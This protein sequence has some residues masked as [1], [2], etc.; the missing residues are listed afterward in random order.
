M[1]N[2][3]P[4]RTSLTE[5][6]TQ[7][8]VPVSTGQAENYVLLLVLLS[9]FAGG[10]LV[11]LSL[12]LLFCHRCCLGGRRYSRAS[13]DPEKT[14]TTYAEDSQPTQ[15]I[16]IRLDESDALSASSC[17]DGESDRF[18]STGSTGRRVSFNESALYDQEKNTQEKGRRYTLTEG[19]FHHLKKARLTHLHLPPAP[20][21]LKILTIMECDSTE[22][23][24][25]NISE[26]SAPN[27][28]L[29]IYQPAERGVPDWLG[30]SLSGGL[31]GDPH[32]STVLDQRDL[33]SSSV[34]KS[35]RSQT[36]E[37]IGD[38]G[39]AESEW[40]P[41]GEPAQAPGP[42]S[43]LHFLSKLRRHASLEG[44]GPYFRR[45][46][47]DTSHRAASLDA[48]GSPKRKP[49]QR[50]RAASE[51]TDHTDE[52]SSPFRDDAFESFPHIPIQTS[53]LQFLSAETL[54]HPETAPTSCIFLRR[55]KLEAMVE[56]GGSATTSSSRRAEL[57][58]PSDPALG[59]VEPAV[60]GT[61]A[62]QET[63]FG[64]AIRTKAT[65]NESE[66]AEDDDPFGAEQGP[67]RRDRF[68]ELLRQTEDAKTDVG[69]AGVRKKNNAG[70][71]EGDDAALG[72]VARRRTDS[73]SSLSFMIRQESSE[74]PPSLYRDI[75]SLRA[76]LEQYA[77][78]DQSSTDRESVRSDADSVSSF[79]GARS[80][81]D[82]CLSQDLDDEPEG[83]GEVEGGT[84]GASGGVG[85]MGNGAGGEA[86]GG[87]RKLLQM[88]SGYA[89]IEA[90]S[91]APEDMRLFGTP[92]APRGK[93]ASERRLFF[94]SSGRK[95]SVCESVETKLFQ[96][97]L[98]DQMA[99]T[100]D[101]EDRL[102]QKSQGDGLSHTLQEPYQLLK[103][104]HPQKPPE[105]QTQLISPL[106]SPTPQPPSPHRSR[107]RRRDYSIDEKT[108]ALFNEFLRH[109]PRFDQQDS[110][111]RSRH[112]SRVHLRKQWQRHKQ[113]SDPGSASGG[114]Y[115]P[116][117][118]RQRFTPLRR[119]DSAGYP[120]DTRYHSTLSRIASAADE[121][122]SEVAASEEAAT[123]RAEDPVGEAA[124][125]GSTAGQTSDGA[126]PTRSVSAELAGETDGCQV[127]TSKE[128][129]SASSTLSAQFSLMDPRVDNRNNNSSQ[130]ILSEVSLQAQ[131]SL[132]DKL[133]AS[134]DERLYGGLRRAEKARQAGSEVIVTHTASP[135]SNPT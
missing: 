68:E 133:V 100:A 77:S 15:E 29:S 131:S 83:D 123:E 95:G 64:A 91:R 122:A 80:G 124:A 55:L 46:K 117:L 25:I 6:S 3:L 74:A 81:L 22:S 1:S 118:E 41:R 75:W 48:K 38:R 7:Q 89:S 85:E 13:D 11:L 61:G 110:P 69:T 99:L 57:C 62:E 63:V 119:G 42:T 72:A 58:F 102:K 97:E 73:G 35:Q 90:P 70:T 108:D 45:W 28:P 10:T 27:L 93:T 104:L 67:T 88:D 14:N 60:N 50:Q 49:F 126:D 109:D 86:E 33:Q 54:P 134:V 26:T 127:S 43:V 51:T 114:R 20:C 94:T 116:S 24:T 128:A 78:S 82:T 39:E 105:T 103:S 18:V 65:R 130:A 71:D 111:L 21:D 66:S 56:V 32:H 8:D 98:E 53:G 113:Y 96:E 44:A 9:V 2:D 92:G 4:V 12:L 120:L 101:T 16:T 135:G 5:N 34:L 31:P 125:A 40:G 112:R 106:V 52:D 23:S 129:G 107:L 59:Q 84:R 47:F 36:M 19:D 76:S 17:H 37:A 30:Q 121:E 79:G 115:S 132:A 87:N